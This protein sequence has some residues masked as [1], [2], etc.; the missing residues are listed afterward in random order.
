[1]NRFTASVLVLVATSS[2]M[3]AQIT[4]NAVVMI[5]APAWVTESKVNRITDKIESKL[6]WDI[7]K[8]QVTWHT[9]T[10][11]K[12]S[13]QSAFGPTN[14]S[15]ENVLAFARRS[16]FSVH[17]GPKVTQSNFDSVFT[18]ELSHV[19]LAQKYKSASASQAA[20]PPWLE[21]GL[22]NYLAG[23]GKVDFKKLAARSSFPDFRQMV[24]PMG[25]TSASSVS[26]HYELSRALV[27][28]IASKCSLMELIQ[29]SVGKNLENYL[30]TFCS[31]SNLNKEFA[32][33]VKRKAKA[34]S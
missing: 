7:R 4:T 5:G 1:M 6:E 16:D 28:F 10:D 9:G 19:I 29:L 25:K 33:W 3:A 22:A 23:Y 17:L 20:V 27:E 8:I 15:L 18:H 34:S 21:E 30:P 32:A 14:Q 2:A 31:I 11:G 26:D 12:A 13:F 24:H